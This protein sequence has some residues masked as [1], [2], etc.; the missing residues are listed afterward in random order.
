MPVTPRGVGLLWVCSVTAAHG[1]RLMRWVLA[2]D[3]GRE[4]GDEPWPSAGPR[5]EANLLLTFPVA[6]KGLPGCGAI[7]RHL[8]FQWFWSLAGLHCFVKGLFTVFA[9]TS[10]SSCLLL[11]WV[12]QNPPAP[13]LLGG[14]ALLRTYSPWARRDKSPLLPGCLQG[15]NSYSSDLK[16]KAKRQRAKLLLKN[17][18]LFF[19]LSSI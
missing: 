18:S 1:T 9:C 19:S 10:C 4:D 6:S 8:K 3:A 2:F 17:I 16:T 5:A 15:T 14:L 13:S 12:P 7:W 11:S